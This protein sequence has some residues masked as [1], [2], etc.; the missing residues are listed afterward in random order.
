[1]IDKI[2]YLRDKLNK[3]LE[4]KLTSDDNVLNLSRELDLLIIDFY[5]HNED[6]DNDNDNDGGDTIITDN[7]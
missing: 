6:D 3:L 5:Y 2:N 1:M 7:E 4:S